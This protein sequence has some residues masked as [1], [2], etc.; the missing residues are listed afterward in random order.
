MDLPSVLLY[1]T[2][3]VAVRR[4]DG[5]LMTTEGEEQQV[6]YVHQDGTMGGTGRV[7]MCLMQ[8]EMMSI[9]AEII[10]ISAHP[11]CNYVWK[12][13]TDHWRL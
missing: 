13:R 10:R 6:L 5:T 3:R 7:A 11:V 2:V 1:R 12:V 8:H 4:P 9:R